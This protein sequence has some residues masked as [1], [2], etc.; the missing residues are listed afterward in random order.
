MSVEYRPVTTHPGY[1]VGTDGSIYSVARS[2]TDRRWRT[3]AIEGK[4]LKPIPTGKGYLGVN[5]PESGKYKRYLIHRLVLAAFVGPCP[6]GMEGCH[7]D[8][9]PENNALEN[10][11]WDTPSANARD[12]IHHGTQFSFR[13]NASQC[14]RGHSLENPMNLVPSKLRIGRRNCLACN[15]A[16]SFIRHHPEL[17]PNVQR[18]SDEKYAELSAVSA[19]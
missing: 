5:L 13:A 17:K 16:Q 9:N 7:S 3:R 11:R 10:L 4:K 2:I 8:G 12:R 19:I 15:R 1:L 18:I 6:D 14:I